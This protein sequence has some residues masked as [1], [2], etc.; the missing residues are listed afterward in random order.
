MLVAALTA[1]TAVLLGGC[2][3]ARYIQTQSAEGSVAQPSVDAAAVC[4]P[5][6]GDDLTQIMGSA[7]QPNAVVAQHTADQTECQ[8]VATNG[9]GFVITKSYR[10]EPR[11][12]FA[13]AFDSAQR[14]LG[15][16]QEI[17]VKGAP[18]A[19]AVPNIGRFGLLT[20]DA[21]IEVNTV[22]PKATADQIMQILRTTAR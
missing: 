3:S 7:F 9:E 2:V 1:G 19:F 21:Y 15:V 5:L 6:T 11:T 12:Q 20:D 14:N 22:F 16:T 8:W 18:G 13:Q 10:T 17:K 4:P